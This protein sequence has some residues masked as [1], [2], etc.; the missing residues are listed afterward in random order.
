MNRVEVQQVFEQIQH[1]QHRLSG[2]LLALGLALELFETLS[3]EEKDHYRQ[4]WCAMHGETLQALQASLATCSAVTAPGFD[5]VTSTA[6]LPCGPALSPMVDV[7]TLRHTLQL[8]SE[9]PTTHAMMAALLPI[10][11]ATATPRLT[12]APVR[13]AAR[14][15]AGAPRPSAAPDGP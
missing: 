2:V 5:E 1:I 6:D 14:P 7:Q 8:A 11:T 4:Y 13:V 12:S 9:Q 10:L 3:S 15:P